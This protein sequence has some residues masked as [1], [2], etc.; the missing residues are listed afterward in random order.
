[1]SVSQFV[2]LGSWLLSGGYNLKSWPS[3]WCLPFIALPLIYLI[4]VAGLIHTTDFSYAFKDLRIK[5]P[6]LALPVLFYTGPQFNKKQ[7]D[8]LLLGMIAG[9]TAAVILGLIKWLGLGGKPITD[10]REISIYVSHIR[11]SLLI[12]LSLIACLWFV[13]AEHRFAPVLVPVALLLFAFLF[14]LESLTGLG[15]LMIVLFVLGIRRS[16]HLENTWWKT[17]LIA[18]T[19]MLP[20]GSAIYVN[21]V[22]DSFRHHDTVDFSTLQSLTPSGNKYQ[23]YPELHDYENGHC[24]WIY[25]CEKEL[26]QQWNKRSSFAYSGKDSRGQ[27]LRFTLIRYLSSKD[28]RKDS[29]GVWSLNKDDIAAVEKGIANIHYKARSSVYGRVHQVIWEIEHYRAGGD[30]SGHSLTMRWV[31]WKTALHIIRD[32]P[33]VGVGTGDLPEAYHQQYITDQTVL[34]EHWQLRAHNQYLS[35]AVAFGIPTLLIFVLILFLVLRHQMR[36]NDTLFLAFWLIAMLSMLTEDTLETQA[37]ATFFTVFYCL[38]LFVNPQKRTCNGNVG[39]L[40]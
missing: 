6:L 30:P 9:T 16:I 36:L 25:V 37:G 38:F 19:V 15:I 18:F 33:W 1:M 35:I 26:E 24:I 14:I 23:H 13:V 4:H 28:L 21:S 17:I 27:D 3:K 32:H 34:S 29:T 12:C 2:M 40:G 20:L 10:I 11:L 31:Y 5:L 7:F 39:P 8:W 22:W